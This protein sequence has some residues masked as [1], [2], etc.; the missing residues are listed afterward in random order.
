MVA[1]SFYEDAVSWLVAEGITGGTS[2]T[3]FSPDNPVTRAQMAA[4]IWR[5][6]NEPETTGHDFSDVDTGVYYDL[7]VGWLSDA[8]I[9]TG[10]SPG[11]FSPDASVL[12]RDM[13]V[14]LYRR[15]C[16]P[17]CSSDLPQTLTTPGD[18]TIY[19]GADT[20]VAYD[21]SGAGGGSG[22]WGSQRGGA[23]TKL[24]GTIPAQDSPY[25]LTVNVAGG[26]GGGLQA[27]G[28]EGGAGGTSSYAPGARGGSLPSGKGKSSGGG[29]GGASAVT[30][31]SKA[32]SIVA[33]GGG[34]SG[35]GAYDS[36]ASGNTGA[37]RRGGQGGDLVAGTV[38][39]A[40]LAGD[41]GG[42]GALA[43]SAL[44]GGGGDGGGTAT[45]GVGGTP[46]NAG[47]SGNNGGSGTDGSAQHGGPGGNGGA[48]GNAAGGG[49][50]GGGHF[51]GGGGGGSA[52]APDAMSVGQSA[53]GGGSG[54]TMVN[55]AG[56]ATVESANNH[57]AGV[58]ANPT[59]G[60]SGGIGNAGGDGT[61]ILGCN[62]LPV[63]TPSA[64]SNLSTPEYTSEEGQ[65][66]TL[67]GTIAPAAEGRSVTLRSKDS[68]GTTE[69]DSTTTDANG[70]FTFT[71]TVDE[72]TDFE[73]HSEAQGGGEATYLAATSDPFEV[74][75]TRMFD[76]FNYTDVS[77]MQPKWF[78]RA[79]TQDY[80]TASDAKRRYTKASFDAI[81]F[82][83]K[84][85]ATEMVFKYVRDGVDPN[86]GKPRYKVPHITAGKIGSASEPDGV[87]YGNL[88]ARIKFSRRL[89]QGAL[90]WQSGYSD[91]GNEFDVVEWFGDRT[92]GSSS[93]QNL[94]HTVHTGP[95]GVGQ[96]LG[97][98]WTGGSLSTG[99]PGQTVFNTTNFGA[100][101][102][103]WSEY[104]DIRG[105][106]N[107]NNYKWYIDGVHV[108]TIGAGAGI[109]PASIPGEVILS[110]AANNGGSYNDLQSFLSGGGDLSS[111]K[112]WIDWVRVWK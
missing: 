57:G 111:L 11:I 72:A 47:G 1:N 10:T 2:A 92:P 73:F 83:T 9:T 55:G 54:S 79:G 95:N 76:D 12:R 23:G 82:Q 89:P 62:E 8:G 90:W 85:G 3:T 4:F 39:D 6:E 63:V 51:G 14:F 60:A 88:E 48:L 69:V 64:F 49:G 45:G 34:G 94:Q 101:D 24:T 16:P 75:S 25:V 27:A 67:T 98:T 78:L 20:P 97:N 103:W 91:Q 31:T 52:T 46:G 38:T 61:V 17:P 81:D 102:T 86:N 110:M 26:G 87:V 28:S 37:N 5:A 59:K 50:A 40:A 68:G 106:W 19:V 96:R 21:V 99:G 112:M 108:G 100:N 35:G 13:A 15:G 84:A 36:S 43:S 109:T 66:V 74:R 71:T 44:R 105:E 53:G 58:E 29:G 18:H 22:A 56:T 65:E 77:Q 104:H 93:T 41:D 70:D 107:T 30:S 42:N 33:P 80:A 7:A 32:I